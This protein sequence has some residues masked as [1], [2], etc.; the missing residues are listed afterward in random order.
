MDGVSDAC[1]IPKGT[2]SL[3]PDDESYGP[4]DIDAIEV[5]SLLHFPLD[6]YIIVGWKNTYPVCTSSC[7]H[8]S[9]IMRKH[10]ADD[11]IG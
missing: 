7:F 5:W 6:F 2:S 11:E 1:Q 10:W 3:I 4:S 8:M 9:I